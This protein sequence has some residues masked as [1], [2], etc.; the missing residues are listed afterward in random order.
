MNSCMWAKVHLSKDEADF[1][2]AIQNMEVRKIETIFEI[3]Q[4]QISHLKIST[5]K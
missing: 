4:A 2:R 3:V 1:K 5:N